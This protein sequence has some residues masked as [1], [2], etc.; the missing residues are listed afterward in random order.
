MT[1]IGHFFIS[2][3]AQKMIYPNIKKGRNDIAQQIIM[4]DNNMGKL[5]SLEGISGT[6]K[7]TVLNKLETIFDKNSNVVFLKEVFDEVHV[8]LGKKIFDSLYYTHDRFFDMGVPYTETMLL[9]A[10]LMYQYECVI[11]NA[12]YNGYTVI[13][14]RGID[15]VI[16]AQAI[17]TQKKYNIDIVCFIDNLDSF[18]KKLIRYPDKTY[19][20]FGCPNTSI[21]R[22][23]MRD[24]IY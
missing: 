13:T 24:Q 11:N 10:R 8:G 23:E 14:D 15:S 22:A 5:I 16:I 18:L 1:R 6:G 3:N 4:I 9:L 12:I 7:T 20:L 2:I 17:M 19:V 21:K